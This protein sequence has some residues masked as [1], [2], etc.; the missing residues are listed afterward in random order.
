MKIALHG[1]PF[2]EKH[3]PF[4]STF[5]DILLNS[6]VEFVISEMFNQELIEKGFSRF[7]NFNLYKDHNNYP[8]VD[9][10]LSIGGDGTLLESLT[11][12]CKK[13]TPI[14]GLNVGRLGYLANVSASEAESAATALLKK[15]YKI[16]ERSMIKLITEENLF[17]D[18]NFGL[19][20]LAIL[21][22][23][24]SS[25]II[26]HTYIDGEFLNSY[27]ADGLLISTPTGSTGYSLSCGGPVLM[28]KSNSF[29]ITPVSP[30]NLNVR[31]L[32]VPDEVSIDFE[33]E[34]RA[35]NFL[36]AL[37]SRSLSVDAGFKLTAKKSLFSAKL[38]T[39]KNVNFLRT[40]RTKLNWGLDNRN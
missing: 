9:C 26:V 32:I 23:D 35:K 13:E 19:N 36:I 5:L 18:L 11:H 20:E 24:T 17:G 29:I 7:S 28:P 3:K 10:H 16:E 4:V 2:E 31:P 33:I 25:M 12:I 30:H 40:L 1:K 22:R 34:G 8:D 6:G 15:D 37:D 14:L 39:L 21:K 27:W 38:V